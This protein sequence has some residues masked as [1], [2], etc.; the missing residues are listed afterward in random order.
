M[1]TLAQIRHVARKDVRHNRWL[2][3]L[4]VVAVVLATLNAF[5]LH[6]STSGPIAID[7]LLIVIFGMAIAAMFVQSDSPSRSNVFWATRPLDSMAVMITKLALV[8]ILIVGVAVVGEIVGLSAYSLPARTIA[9]LV[10]RSIGEYAAWLLPAV[11]IA[12]F[13]ADF[14]SFA[15]ALLV[16]I[17]AF[18][19]AAQLLTDRTGGMH[20]PVVIAFLGIGVALAT[21]AYCYRRRDPRQPLLLRAVAA[22]GLFGALT[23]VISSPGPATATPSVAAVNAPLEL[24]DSGATVQGGYLVLH[25]YGKHPDEKRSIRFLCDTTIVHLRDGSTVSLVPRFGPVNLHN[26]AIPVAD[27]IRYRIEARGAEF[28]GVAYQLDDTERSALAGGMTSIEVA[29]RINEYSPSL[30]ASLPLRVGTTV[31]ENGTRFGIAGVGYTTDSLTV[32][33]VRSSVL[34]PQSFSAAGN[35]AASFFGGGPESPNF[36]LVNTARHETIPLQNHSTSSSSSWVVLPGAPL[37]QSSLQLIPMTN[38]RSHET[39]KPDA[40]WVRDARLVLIDW[41]SVASYRVHAELPVR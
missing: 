41:K 26:A 24:T 32:N 40:N 20:I 27:S 16:G 6:G 31:T 39:I 38:P 4:Y 1:T 36:V 5:T 13:T 30:S 7:V 28:S 15:M 25:L 29:G 10:M 33:L 19:L 37:Q 17:F 14:R 3:L 18:F 23:L 2:L 35:T 34:P 12:A 9:G 8:T 22:L 11:I 21:L